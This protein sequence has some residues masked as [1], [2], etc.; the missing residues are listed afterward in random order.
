MIK[1]MKGKVLQAIFLQRDNPSAERL[2]KNS[3]K[4]IPLELKTRN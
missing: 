4:K 3:Y 2:S 1:A